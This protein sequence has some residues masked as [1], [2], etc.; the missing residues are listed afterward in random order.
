[1]VINSENFANNLSVIFIK[2]KCQC[3]FYKISMN[4]SFY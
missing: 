1:M 3:D 2:N 4:G